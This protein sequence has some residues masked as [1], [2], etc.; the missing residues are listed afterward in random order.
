MAEQDDRSDYLK[1][2]LNEKYCWTDADS[3]AIVK[4]ADES[5]SEEA[6]RAHMT[7]KGRRM[8]DAVAEY[9][10]MHHFFGKVDRAKQRNIK[11]ACILDMNFN[12]SRG[13]VT[14]ATKA[15]SDRDFRVSFV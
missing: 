11:A 6:K 9:V 14:K 2:D 1:G 13:Y 3:A 12:L 10:L 7:E 4:D 8:A 5:E 15:F